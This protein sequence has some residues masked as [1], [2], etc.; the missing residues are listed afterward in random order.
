MGYCSA[1]YYVDWA[2]DMADAAVAQILRLIEATPDDLTEQ[3]QRAVDDA[4][5]PFLA[6]IAEKATDDDWD[7]QPDSRY[8]DRFRDVIDPNDQFG[9][10]EPKGVRD[11]DPSGHH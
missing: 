5:R 8:F 11:A 6:K 2:V 1:T 9:Y 10:M 7:C 3:Q 4:M